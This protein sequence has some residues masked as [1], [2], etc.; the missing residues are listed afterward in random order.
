VV[1]YRRAP[2]RVM[3]K[4]M[5]DLTTVERPTASGAC[6]ILEGHRTRPRAMC[7]I[8]PGKHQREYASRH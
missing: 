3:A 5:A 1:G 7:R 6:S 4:K 2:S 8:G